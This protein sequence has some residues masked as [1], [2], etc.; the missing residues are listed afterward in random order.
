[1]AYLPF[2]QQMPID[3]NFT[4]GRMQMIPNGLAIHVTD[5][6]RHQL[7]NLGGVK[8]SFN[9]EG[10]HVSAHF[11]VAKDGTIAHIDLVQKNLEEMVARTLGD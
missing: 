1:M 11:C 7:P 4:P 3:R 6:V 2:V 10:A 9:V 8:S 5:G